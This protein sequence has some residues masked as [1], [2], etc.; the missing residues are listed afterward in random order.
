LRP[1]GIVTAVPLIVVTSPDA[2]PS[3]LF[4]LIVKFESKIALPDGVMVRSPFAATVNSAALA[5]VF[6]NLS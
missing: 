4:P 3:V 6:V 5:V 1:F 2:L